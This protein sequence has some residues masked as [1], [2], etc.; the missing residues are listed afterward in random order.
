MLNHPGPLY[1][2]EKLGALRQDELAKRHL[3]AMLVRSTIDDSPV[4]GNADRPRRRFAFRL[5]V[6]MRLSPR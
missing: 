2:Q 4:V 6:F 1:A 5:P 3:R